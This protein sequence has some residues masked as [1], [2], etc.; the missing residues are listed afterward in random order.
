MEI[1][2]LNR[3]IKSFSKG[4]DDVSSLDFYYFFLQFNAKKEQ[5]TSV[6]TE[7]LFNKDKEL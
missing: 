6:L 4:K 1:E 7:N 5:K 2:V 3:K